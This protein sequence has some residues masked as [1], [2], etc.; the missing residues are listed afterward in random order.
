MDFVVNKKNM[1]DLTY[2][3]NTMDEGT[4]DGSTIF[5]ITCK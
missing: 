3:L 5:A 2:A 4:V 1:N